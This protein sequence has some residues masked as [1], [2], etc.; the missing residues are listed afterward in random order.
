MSLFRALVALG[1]L[2]ASVVKGLDLDT[3]T[4]QAQVLGRQRE[5]IMRQHQSEDGTVKPMLI[6]VEP[7]KDDLDGKCTKTKGCKLGCCGPL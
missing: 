2:Y 7:E 4:G 6:M 3:F 5:M 1:F